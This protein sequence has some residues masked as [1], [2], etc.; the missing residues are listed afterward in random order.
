MSAEPRRLHA[1]AGVLAVALWAVGL[2]VYLGLTPQPPAHASGAVVLAWAQNHTNPIILGAWIF[3]VGWLCFVWFAGI[4]RER[5]AAREDAGT[6]SSIAF[7][8]A[9]AAAIFGIGMP[10]GDLV[11]AIDKNDVDPATAGTLHHLTD[12]FFVGAELSLVLFLAA[13]V[14]AAWRT[15]ALPRW[16]AILSAL[17]AAVLLIGPIGWAGLM[18]GTPVW[19]LGTTALLFRRPAARRAAAAAEPAGAY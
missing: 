13:V 5:L 6:F 1:L 12:L 17:L 8:G 15:G 3:M 11:I 19:V 14:A 9:V 7:G 10:A 4:L 16:W 2:L 18:F